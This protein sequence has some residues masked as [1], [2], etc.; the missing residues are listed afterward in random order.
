MFTLTSSAFAPGGS[1][2]VRHTCD[3]EDRS[4]ALAWSDTPPG[5][6]SLVL[7]VDDPDCP[8]PAAPRRTWV[9]WIRYNLPPSATE[10]AE[11]A[12]NHEPEA[13]TDALTDDDT[14]GWH[15]PCPPIGRHRYFFRLHT[16]DTVLPDLGPSARRGDVERAMG[17][18]VLATA[19][20]MGTCD[21]SVRH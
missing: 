14:T 15:G 7:I 21:R 11:G 2:P 10:L 5:T 16:L 19:T 8:D 1:I 18:H 17:G 20:L 3:G 12:G 4:P 9:H 6:R 13:G